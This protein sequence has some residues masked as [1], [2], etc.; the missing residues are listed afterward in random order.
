[1]TRLLH[2]YDSTNFSIDSRKFCYDSTISPPSCHARYQHWFAD[3][4]G[5]TK[6]DSYGYSYFALRYSLMDDRLRLSL[7]VNDPFHQYITDETNYNGLASLI[8]SIKQMIQYSHT[9]HHAHYI[10][11]TATYSFG[12]KKVR[13]IQHDKKDTESQRA[14]IQRK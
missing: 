3:Y 5:M 13:R 4:T 8:T 1:M 7:V 9:N 14:E 12:G 11:L 2:R 10:G 6:T